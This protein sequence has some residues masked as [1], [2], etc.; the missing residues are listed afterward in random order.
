[1]AVPNRTPLDVKNPN[2]SVFDPR[3][4]WDPARDKSPV[5]SMLVKLSSG[6]TAPQN[7]EAPAVN[8]KDAPVRPVF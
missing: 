7:Q 1:M 6:I 5:P 8:V 4:T 3:L 2:V